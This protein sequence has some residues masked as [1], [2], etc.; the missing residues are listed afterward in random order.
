MNLT[1]LQ[2]AQQ[3]GQFG[4][5]NGA[6]GQRTDHPLASRLGPLAIT[7]S[8]LGKAGLTLLEADP[9]LAGQAGITHPQHG[10]DDL[11][12]AALGGKKSFLQTRTEALLRKT[13]QGFRTREMELEVGLT[14]AAARQGLLQGFTGEK[15]LTTALQPLLLE[16]HH[17][18]DQL[19]LLSAQQLRHKLHPPHEIL[20]GQSDLRPLRQEIS[21]L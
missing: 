13:T 11:V 7:G 14:P 4:W 12:V 19:L 18:G 10:V 16:G 20:N 5:R 21:W 2:G 1:G 6:D 9:E 3:L 15:S 17:R 8:H